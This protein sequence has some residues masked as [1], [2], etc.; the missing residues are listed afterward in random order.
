MAGMRYHQLARYKS[1][2]RRAEKLFGKINVSEDTRSDLFKGLLTYK[3]AVKK[4][5]RGEWLNS[6]EAQWVFLIAH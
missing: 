4:L 5:F 3:R 1:R 6:N 2:G